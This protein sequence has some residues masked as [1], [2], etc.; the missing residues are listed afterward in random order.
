MKTFEQF[1]KQLDKCLTSITTQYAAIGQ[2]LLDAEDCLASKLMKELEGYLVARGLTANDIKA[3]KKIALG[4]IQPSL[5]M[6]GVASS[7]LLNLSHEDQ[8]RLLSGEKFDIKTADGVV[9]LSWDKMH[10]SQRNQLVGPKGG[11]ILPAELQHVASEVNKEK[12]KQIAVYDEVDFEPCSNKLLLK[13]GNRQ[14]RVAIADILRC[15]EENGKLEQFM[16]SINKGSLV[17]G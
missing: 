12:A 8:A 10:P 4:E 9:Q 5:F 3:A 16:T 14:G 15:L 6:S 7:K 2:V 11:S 17:N 1:K 13:S